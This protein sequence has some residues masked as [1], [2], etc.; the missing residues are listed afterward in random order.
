MVI[1]R[2]KALNLLKRQVIKFCHIGPNIS[3]EVDWVK[4]MLVITKNYIGLPFTRNHT[5]ICIKIT[6]E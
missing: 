4:L 3:F 2:K 1:S 6:F 5:K